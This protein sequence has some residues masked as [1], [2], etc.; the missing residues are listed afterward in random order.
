MER[1]SLDPETGVLFTHEQAE[2]TPSIWVL[3]Y[4]GLL[5]EQDIFT[6]RKNCKTTVFK[7]KKKKKNKDNI[8]EVCNGT[9]YEVYGVKR[10]F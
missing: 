3:G 4:H 10:H 6:T 1:S 9:I 7:K 2:D 8:R 5:G